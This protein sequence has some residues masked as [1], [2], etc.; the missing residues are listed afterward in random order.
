MVEHLK[1]WGPL[2]LIA[3]AVV[4]VY[5]AGLNHYVSPGFLKTQ[6]D[7]LKGFVSSHF[8]LSLAAFTAFFAL[9]TTTAVPGAVFAQLAGGFLFGAWLGGAAIALAATVGALAIYGVARTA[10]GDALRRRM[11]TKNGALKRLQA[12]LDQHS[13]WFLLA[14]RLAPVVPFVLVNIASGVARIPLRRYA[15]ATFLGTL[16]TNLVYA[17]IG[18]G[19][20]RIFAEGRQADLRLLLDSRVVEPLL[21]LA[22]LSLLPVGVRLAWDRWGA[23]RAV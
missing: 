14:V 16:P 17:W 2:A 13:F 7:Q 6:H 5:A 9:I 12:G 11:R 19:L 8:W 1:R 21:F 10:A 3:L 22:L 23:R 20:D 4:V 15:V 18:A